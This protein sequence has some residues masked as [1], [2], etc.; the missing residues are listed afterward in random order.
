MSKFTDK[1]KQK[2]K[3]PVQQGPVWKGPTVDGITF[4]LLSRFLSCRERFRILTIKGIKPNPTFNPKASYGNMWHICEEEY[5]A[6][7]NWYHFDQLKLYAN[8]LAAEYPQNHHEIAKWYNVVKVQFPIYVDYWSRQ[9]DNQH[10]QPIFQEEVFDVVYN[11]PSG[12]KVRLRG[13][14]DS[15]DYISK[16]MM[17]GVWLQE[18]KSKGDPKPLQIQRQLKFDLQTM[19]YLVVLQELISIHSLP[20]S[21]QK[22]CVIKG[23]RYNV[24]RRPLSGGKGSIVQHKP[25]KKNPQ[26]ESSEDYYARLSQI[27]KDSPQDFFMRWDVEI[28]QKDIDNFK[29]K[30]FNPLLEQLCDWYDWVKD[31]KDP[32]RKPDR[33]GLVYSDDAEPNGIHYQ[34]PFGVYNVLDEGGSSDLDEYLESGSMVGLTRVDDLFPELK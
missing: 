21:P 15:V 23:V 6:D 24:I 34:H 19:L 25:T 16:G 13:K 17:K 5:A 20:I 33:E 28:N 2:I 9:P 12:R 10:K 8:E 22:D 31:G 14:F 7:N 18:N 4:S 3:Q 27:I 32:W 29:R 26:G 11:L 30:C 1:V